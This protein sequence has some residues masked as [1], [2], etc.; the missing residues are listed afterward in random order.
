M[1]KSVFSMSKIESM[2]VCCSTFM[3]GVVF[4]FF[5]SLF[6]VCRCHQ[7]R[8]DGHSI[9][10]RNNSNNLCMCFFFFFYLQLVKPFGL[11]ADR[12]LLRCLFSTIDFS[13]ASQA[14]KNSLQSKLLSQELNN[15]L[16]KSSLI[17]SIC[18]AI[19]NSFN[20]QKVCCGHI[21]VAPLYTQYTLH[22]THTHY[23]RS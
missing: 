10:K 12:H 1:V 19:D 17:S 21:P 22:T 18:F 5:F 16:N 11:E 3:L 2:R 23:T 15:L 6:V 14:A 13:D 9:R 20:T 7:V 8:M 4:F